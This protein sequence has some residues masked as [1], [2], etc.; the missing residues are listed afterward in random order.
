[1]TVFSVMTMSSVM[2]VVF[3]NWNGSITRMYRIHSELSKRLCTVYKFYPGT[4][5]REGENLHFQHNIKK[6]L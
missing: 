6:S 2:I 1:M 4:Q 5:L 3:E